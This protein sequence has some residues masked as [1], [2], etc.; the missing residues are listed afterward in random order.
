MSVPDPTVYRAFGSKVTTEHAP[1][2]KCWE[3]RVLHSYVSSLDW[4]VAH[5]AVMGEGLERPYIELVASGSYDDPDCDLYVV[6]L[7]D[8]TPEEQAAR[9]VAE[10]QVREAELELY[11]SL[12]A[13]YERSEACPHCGATDAVPLSL[14]LSCTNDWHNR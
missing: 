2:G 12:K 3:H 4:I 6:G 9:A 13:K 8:I 5:L 10:Q 7:R 1:E 11:A 14:G